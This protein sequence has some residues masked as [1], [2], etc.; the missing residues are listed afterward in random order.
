MLQGMNPNFKNNGCQGRNDT[1]DDA[2]ND[3]EI[4]VAD[5][6]KPPVLE[7]IDGRLESFFDILN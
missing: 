7:L 1:D 5:M 2:G 3:Q 4:T 6:P